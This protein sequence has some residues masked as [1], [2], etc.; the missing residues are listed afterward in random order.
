LLV[1]QERQRRQ[2]ASSQRKRARHHHHSPFSASDTTASSPPPRRHLSSRKQT[3][4]EKCV[5]RVPLC[6]LAAFEAIHN[7]QHQ[8]TTNNKQQKTITTINIACNN[9]TDLII[10]D[11]STTRMQQLTFSHNNKNNH[12]KCDNG[13]VLYGTVTSVVWSKQHAP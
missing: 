7:N 5:C 10:K 8:S 3:Q 9:Q 12:V 11:I 13:V 2:E 4:V 1:P 6:A